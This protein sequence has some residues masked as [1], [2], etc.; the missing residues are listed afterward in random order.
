[1]QTECWAGPRASPSAGLA[2]RA[3]T[4]PALSW[5]S[6][7][8]WKKNLQCTVV[9]KMALKPIWGNS[10][11]RTRPLGRFRQKPVWKLWVKITIATAS[12]ISTESSYRGMLARSGTL[13]RVPSHALPRARIPEAEAE[14]RPLLRLKP[15]RSSHPHLH[16][17]EQ[18]PSYH[19]VLSKEIRKGKATCTGRLKYRNTF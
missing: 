12:L 19:R 7:V 5:A 17:A 11:F 8:G 3:R 6:T 18:A 2:V 1:M 14:V 9:A 10:T 4:T 13:L 15:L 16:S